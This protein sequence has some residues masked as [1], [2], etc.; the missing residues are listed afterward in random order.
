[1][2]HR[3]RPLRRPR[4]LCERLPTPRL[5]VICRVPHA[6]GPAFRSGPRRGNTTPRLYPV[7]QA[8]FSGLRSVVSSP[9]ATA[10]TPPSLRTSANSAP[11]RCHLPGAACLRSSSVSHSL[12]CSGTACCATTKE[13]GAFPLSVS[14]APLPQGSRLVSGSAPSGGAL[15][16]ALRR[17]RDQ[18]PHHKP[19]IRRPLR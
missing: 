6:E 12:R 11:L 10:T 17:L 15:A 18:T 2:S 1:L 3:P 16:W 13:S 8:C 4:L 19:A 14:R 5:C 9:T 7:A